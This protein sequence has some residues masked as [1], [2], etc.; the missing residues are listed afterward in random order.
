MLGDR[1]GDGCA[2][3]I[4]RNAANSAHA[5]KRGPGGAPGDAAGAMTV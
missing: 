2:G 3:L 4:E 1:D 5:D